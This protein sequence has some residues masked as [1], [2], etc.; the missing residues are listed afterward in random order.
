M[1]RQVV[2]IALKVSVQAWVVGVG[3]DEL[4]KGGAHAEDKDR[5]A[6][7]GGGDGPRCGGLV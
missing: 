4:G 3:M 1:V 7:H 6:G 5:Q 2:R